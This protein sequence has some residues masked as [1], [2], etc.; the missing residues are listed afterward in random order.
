MFSVYQEIY[1][2]KYRRVYIRSITNMSAI[3]TMYGKN[4]LILLKI[5]AMFLTYPMFLYT[6]K[7]PRTTWLQLAENP[8]STVIHTFCRN[9]IE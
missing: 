3:E 7:Q 6:E 5:S 8:V 2:K 4:L 1:Q 9:W